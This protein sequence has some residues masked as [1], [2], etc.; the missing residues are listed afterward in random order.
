MGDLSLQG[1]TNCTTVY[2]IYYIHSPRLILGGG[3]RLGVY[4]T[5]V[6]EDRLLKE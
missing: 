2:Y 1:M 5:L 4:G 6:R 3:I